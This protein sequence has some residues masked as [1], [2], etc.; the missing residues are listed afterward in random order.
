M[1]KRYLIG[2][3]LGT[4]ATKAAL[5]RR[6]AQLSPRHGAR[7]RS[8]T[9]SR[10]WWSRRTT[11]STA[12][13]RRPSA[14]IGDSGVDPRDVAAIAFDSQMAGIGSIDEDFRPATRFDSW[15]DMRCQ[16]YIEEMDRQHGDL[17]TG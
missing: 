5:Y 4:S 2:V 10:A 13:L 6:T 3:D 15:L 8:T 9:P 11:T 7:C 14:C 12:P 16:P 1:S 17:I